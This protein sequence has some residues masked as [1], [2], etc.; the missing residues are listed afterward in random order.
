MSE[1]LL[2]WLDRKSIDPDVDPQ[3]R[4]LLRDESL[5]IRGAMQATPR[6]HRPTWERGSKHPDAVAV[7]RAWEAATAACDVRIAEAIEEA[8]RTARLW[9]L[10]P[11]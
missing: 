6:A 8:R 1:S 11:P 5:A 3:L 7:V 4:R 10:T 9:G 2:G